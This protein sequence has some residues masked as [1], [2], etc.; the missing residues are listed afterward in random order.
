MSLKGTIFSVKAGTSVPDLFLEKVIEQNQSF[1]GVAA[2]IQQDGSPM[3]VTIL[4][5]G[6]TSL[7]DVKDMLEEYKDTTCLWHFG[8]VE[9]AFGDGDVQP[10][11]VIQEGGDEASPDVVMF[12][13]GMFEDKGGEAEV[14]AKFI[15]PYLKKIW[16]GCADVPE[17]MEE[18]A[19]DA[20]NAEQMKLYYQSRGTITVLGS[21]GMQVTFGEN[22][23]HKEY[24]WGWTSNPCG[25]VEE[26][27][28]A[29]VAAA[30]VRRFG[31]TSRNVTATPVTSA[32]GKTVVVE[33]KQT[34]ASVPAAPK[35]GG[36]IAKSR[37]DKPELWGPGADCDTKNKIKEW[38]V[39]NNNGIIPEGYKDR[40]LVE[41][42]PL[43]SFDA[44]ATRPIASVTP[45]NAGKGS[46]ATPTAQST[47]TTSTVNK[48][49]VTPSK[50]VTNEVLPVAPPKQKEWLKNTFMK[51]GSVQR[52]VSDG[53]QIIDPKRMQATEAKFP[54]YVEMAGLTDLQ[55]VYHYTPEDRILLCKE[56]PETTAIL[57]MNL[58]FELE[59]RW[60]IAAGT[61]VAQSEAP[62]SHSAAAKAP[63]ARSFGG[64]RKVS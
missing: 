10:I 37:A 40:P 54:T 39:K 41:K 58:S 28:E 26:A 50:Q 29:P 61:P 45:I 56:A 9:G 14:A 17:F 1:A 42:G 24:E 57:L 15:I 22:A 18:L 33:K 7:E 52:T 59:R 11:T 13:E 38:Y 35:S 23:L 27:A 51:R 49:E 20:S 60:P 19:T 8:N 48:T 64:G 47:T 53:Q 34:A 30:P 36:E 46:N 25:Y 44:L 4:N 12:L 32:A 5:S 63:V 3:L 55:D 6:P 21:N 62:S 16:K 2:A 43:K 31:N